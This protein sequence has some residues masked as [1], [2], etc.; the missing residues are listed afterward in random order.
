MQELSNVLSFQNS[1]TQHSF[2]DIKT[3][4]KFSNAAFFRQIMLQILQ[5]RSLQIHVTERIQRNFENM[6]PTNPVFKNLIFMACMFL[7]ASCA[8]ELFTGK[9]TSQDCIV[10]PATFICIVI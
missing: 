7:G 9:P 5:Q 6:C 1:R 8:E 2:I 10:Q 3:V 4:I